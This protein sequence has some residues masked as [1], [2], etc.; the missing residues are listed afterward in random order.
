[1]RTLVGVVLDRSGSMSSVLKDTIGGFNTFVETQR[2]EGADQ[3]YVFTQFDTEYEVIQDGVEL[4]DV[5]V[6]DRKNYVPRGGTALLDAMGQTIHRMDAVLA[7][8]KSI[9]QAIMVV[10]TDGDENSS[11]EF[12]NAQ[13]NKLIDERSAGVWDFVFLG[14][15]QDAIAQATS[16]GISLHN[17]LSFSGDSVGTQRALRKM[18]ASVTNYS[19]GESAAVDNTGETPVVNDTVVDNPNN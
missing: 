12:S 4:D 6:L 3:I 1:M 5:I 7:N 18:S 19:A 11:K 13:I 15:G 8:D 10:L 17:T 16:L 14:A 2:Q 9:E